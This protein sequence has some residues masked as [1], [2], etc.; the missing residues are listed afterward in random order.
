[1]EKVTLKL[2]KDSVSELDVIKKKKCDFSVMDRSASEPS[3]FVTTHLNDAEL[4]NLP[5]WT[6]ILAGGNGIKRF[7]IKLSV[8]ELHKQLQ[9][10]FTGCR[11]I[12]I[13]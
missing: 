13:E 1:M 2:V 5:G 4:I 6:L 8:D 12:W 11:V 9:V 3:L 7:N 10:L